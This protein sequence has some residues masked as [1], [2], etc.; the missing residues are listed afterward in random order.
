M[1]RYL[2]LVLLFSSCEE[3]EY[4][5]HPKRDWAFENHHKVWKAEMNQLRFADTTK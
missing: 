4:S 1:K 2:L 5:F 3:D